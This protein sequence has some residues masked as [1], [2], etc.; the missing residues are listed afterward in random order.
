MTTQ[1]D[2]INA[3]L[4]R[5]DYGARAL[6]PILLEIQEQHHY[7]PEDL[8]R[9]VAEKTQ[10]PLVQVYQ[11]AA[12]YSAFSLEPR[13]EHIVTVCMGTAC[14]VLGSQMVMDRLETQLGIQAGETTADGLATLEGVNC[15][16]ACA[17]GPIVI[18]DSSYSGQMSPQKVDRLVKR[19]AKKE[20]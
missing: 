1:I 4:A 8:L 2:D 7:L 16:G 11:V 6:I 12:F 18:I 5:H 15:V 14:H 17:L 9:Q 20:T 10:V 13:G 3:I 19:L